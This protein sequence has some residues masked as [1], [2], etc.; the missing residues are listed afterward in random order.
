MKFWKFGAGI[1]ALIAAALLQ[2]YFLA[3]ASANRPQTAPKAESK[4]AAVS[5]P[6]AKKPSPAP[7]PAPLSPVDAWMRQMTL[8]D[9]VAQLVVAPFHGDSAN[10]RSAHYR[11]TLRLVRDVRVGGLI[12]IGKVQSGS[13]RSAEPHQMAAFLNRMQ[14]NAKVPLL[15][16]G[17]FERG[18]S[19]RVSSTTKYPHI[20]AYA[21]AGDLDATRNL[22]AATAREAR[23]MGVHWVFAPV[24]DVNNNPENPIINI[25]SFG[26]DPEQVAAHVQAFL[27][28]AHGD[29]KNRVLATVKHFPGHG[30]T[31]VDS[32]MGLANLQADR[33]R[34]ERVELVPF[35]AAVRKNVD[36]VMTAHMAVPAIE[37][38]EIP[39]TVSPAI[40]NGVLRNEL[41][42]KGLIVT[43]AMDMHGLSKQLPP[44]EA[45]VRAIEAGADILLMPP[46]P[47]EAIQ[48]VVKAVQSGR[49]SSKRIDESVARVLN[50]K[51]RVGLHRQRIVNL[52]T[53]GD[54]I[55]TP[56]AAEDAQRVADRS[57]TMVRNA[58]GLIPI[59]QPENHCFIILSERRGSTQGA[60][61]SEE[62]RKR[63]ANPKI[64]WLDPGVNE[65]AAKKI[66]NGAAKSDHIT[67]FAFVSVSAYR[68]N[69]ALPGNYAPLM[70][71]LLKAKRP[72]TLVSLGNPYILR[73]FPEVSAY[74]TTYSPVI[75]S[76]T[77][78]VRAL[79]G[80][81]PI[82]GRLPVSIPGYASVGDGIQIAA[83][84]SQPIPDEIEEN[85]EQ[86]HVGNHMA[87]PQH[88]SVTNRER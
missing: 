21:A 1:G 28:G 32:H 20:M 51:V 56:E 29:P 44:G 76:E 39:A 33:T 26:E 71:M 52:E 79:F 43:D 50:A 65:P 27:D 4:K 30:D 80:E 7:K 45:A 11:E 47:E 25:R 48:A 13:I 81:I 72:V 41:R 3:P 84:A 17:D 40:L 15:V 88:L 19:M 8:R 74:L 75:T 82:T 54:Q 57:V 62:L 73:N 64:I 58:N 34:I 87:R 69:V 55:D 36:A 23:A 59:R 16:A 38:E 83:T 49:I 42:F 86:A 68:G 12:V 14:R 22:G 5:E 78:A 70:E 61:I 53:I 6:A 46:K 85:K 18:A 37:A 10:A 67:V 31:T 24:A 77:S 35:R 2:S 60:R 9:K 63:V 66:V